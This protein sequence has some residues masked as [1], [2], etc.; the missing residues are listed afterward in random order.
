MQAAGNAVTLTRGHFLQTDLHDREV[1][2]RRLA[3][4]NL[5]LR[6]ALTEQQLLVDEIDHRVKNNLQMVT[7]LIV[8]QRR[9]SGNPVIREA[10][11]SMLARV[12]ALGLMQRRLYQSGDLARFDL[13]EFCR[14]LAN[15]LHAAAS[16]PELQLQ[17]D[18]DS[19]TV[20]AELAPP[21]A[22]IANEIVTN[23]LKHAF[24]A[25]RAGTLAIS[26]HQE[27][28]WLRL[29]VADDGVGID[30]AHATDA[31]VSNIDGESASFGRLLV[32]SLGKQL[33]ASVEWSHAAP[34]TRVQLSMPV[35]NTSAAADTR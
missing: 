24:A 27:A 16:R 31:D 6:A 33:R 19:V 35:A 22:L 8:M 32:E 30:A 4:T 25:G 9:S 28:G 7:S 10:L 2:N 11:T 29:T 23:A 13:T 17:L 15:E 1:A 21:L 3:Q 18:L 34:G 20:P 14:E 26:L 5:K 12:E